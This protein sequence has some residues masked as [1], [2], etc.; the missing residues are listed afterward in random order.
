[1]SATCQDKFQTQAENDL[2]FFD[3][4]QEINNLR[5]IWG[6]DEFITLLNLTDYCSKINTLSIDL[7][8]TLIYDWYRCC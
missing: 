3:D 2:W 5:H 4:K 8:F 7:P 6:K 1:M